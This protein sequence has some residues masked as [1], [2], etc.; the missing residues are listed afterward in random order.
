VASTD[1]SSGDKLKALAD[2]GGVEKN[3]VMADTDAQLQADLPFMTKNSLKKKTGPG[4]KS[5]VTGIT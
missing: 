2:A 5:S 1:N 3:Y 4:L